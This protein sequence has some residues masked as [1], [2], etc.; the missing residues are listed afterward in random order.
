M[1][2]GNVIEALVEKKRY[3]PYRDSKLTR[4]MS[5]SFGGNSYTSII[6]NISQIHSNF[7]ETL[8]TLQFG[9]RAN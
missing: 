9:D 3:I 5:N 7:Y 8:S 1:T 2:L 4:L 6:L